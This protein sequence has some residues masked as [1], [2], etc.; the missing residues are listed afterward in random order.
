MWQIKKITT[1]ISVIVFFYNR[2]PIMVKCLNIGKPIYR[3]IS[4]KYLHIN[5][6]I[7]ELF[8]L[9]IIGDIAVPFKPLSWRG[10]SHFKGIIFTS[11]SPMEDFSANT[12]QNMTS[13]IRQLSSGWCILPC[14]RRAWVG[15]Y[16]HTKKKKKKTCLS[17][18]WKKNS[19]E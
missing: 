15:F 1:K 17:N 2:Y 12:D 3:S 9:V 6:Q 16:Q 5:Q 4:K 7:L 10:G 8:H 18:V 14:Q 19:L 13:S 11:K